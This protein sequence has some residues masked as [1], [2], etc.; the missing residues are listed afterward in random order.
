[1]WWQGN[2]SESSGRVR[3]GLWTLTQ[4]LIKGFFYV[5]WVPALG[6]LWRFRDRFRLVPG[7]WVLLLVGLIVGFLLY[8]LA[9]AV[10]YLSDRPALLIILPGCYWAVAGLLHWGSGLAAALARLRPVL[11]G[12]VWTS[13]RFGSALLLTAF[14]GV[15][16]VKTLEPLHVNR[17]GFRQAGYWLAANANPGDEIVD[18]YCWSHYY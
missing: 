1:S 12:T 7:A 13:G 10:G 14:V 18:A 4:E 9:V 15:A 17:L 16:L 6:G 11:A 2:L 5:L 8:R 3:W